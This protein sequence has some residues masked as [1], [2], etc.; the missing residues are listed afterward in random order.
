M[1]SGQHFET[2]RNGPEDQIV[3]ARRRL[4]AVYDAFVLRFGPL[5]TRENLKAFAGDPDQP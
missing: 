2:S 1:G 5:S 3:A 4:N